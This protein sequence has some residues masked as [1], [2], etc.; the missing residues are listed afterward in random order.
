M[1]EEELK[2]DD[3]EK[4]VRTWN[5]FQECSQADQNIEDFLSNFDLAYKTAI[6]ASSELT[7]SAPVRAFMVLK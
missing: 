2:E 1:R 3:L 7:I 5:E 6:G 4:Q